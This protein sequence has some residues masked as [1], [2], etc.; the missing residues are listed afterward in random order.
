MEVY[1]LWLAE[2]G[3]FMKNPEKVFASLQEAQLQLSQM[4][5]CSC[6]VA[7]ASCLQTDLSPPERLL[8]GETV[9]SSFKY[10]KLSF[11]MSSETGESMNSQY[12]SKN[13][14]LVSNH[15]ICFLQTGRVWFTQINAS[16]YSF[17]HCLTCLLKIIV[18]S[19][20]GSECAWCMH[21]QQLISLPLTFKTIYKGAALD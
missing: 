16:Q 10:N 20:R 9:P 7:D 19:V 5:K 14:A 4:H 17:L 2:T 11:T 21:L 12:F 15:L 8:A 13:K 6:R 1:H 3:H 18:S